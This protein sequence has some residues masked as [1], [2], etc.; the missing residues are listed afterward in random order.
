MKKHYLTFENIRSALDTNNISS[1]EFEIFVKESISA[2][3][4][5]ESK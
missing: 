2:C 4:R 3:A 1:I 5:K